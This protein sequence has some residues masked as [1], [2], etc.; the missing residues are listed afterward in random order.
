MFLNKHPEIQAKI[1]NFT[2][3]HS[4]KENVDLLG[5]ITAKMQAKGEKIGKVISNEKDKNI[6]AAINE[7][8]AKIT[9]RNGQMLHIPAG[10]ALCLSNTS[11]NSPSRPQ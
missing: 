11:R 8:I 2:D 9:V 7:K 10:S 1:K 5:K 6:T 4:Y 3:F